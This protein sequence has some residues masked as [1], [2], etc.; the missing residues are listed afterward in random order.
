VCCRNRADIDRASILAVR[1]ASGCANNQTEGMMKAGI[2]AAAAA[3]IANSPMSGAGG[4]ASSRHGGAETRRPAWATRFLG[5]CAWCS[6]RSRQRRAL[7]QL[8]D[9]LLKDIGKTRQQAMTEAAKPFW[10]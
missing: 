4:A 6:A 7:A 9:R 2:S 10:K 3:T 1:N 8:D 5:W